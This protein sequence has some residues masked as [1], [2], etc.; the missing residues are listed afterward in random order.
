VIVGAANCSVAQKS[1]RFVRTRPSGLTARSSG[2]VPRFLRSRVR[3][4][5]GP[6]SHEVELAPRALRPRFDNTRKKNRSKKKKTKKEKNKKRHAKQN[7]CDEITTSPPPK[8]ISP[9]LI[10]RGPAHP[11]PSVKRRPGESFS[12]GGR[13]GRPHHPLT[14]S[15]NDEFPF[16]PVEVDRRPTS[17]ENAAA[18]PRT[19]GRPERGHLP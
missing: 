8:A 12:G 1:A 3:E 7:P 10:E 11:R 4:G 19:T 2:A 9:L 16:L 13:S 15:N 14:A 18:R 17:S 6:S 5:G